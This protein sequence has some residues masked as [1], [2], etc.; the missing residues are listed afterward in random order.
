MRMSSVLPSIKCSTC[1]QDIPLSELGEH[2]C[3]VV[4]ERE[5]EPRCFHEKLTN[6]KL[7]LYHRWTLESTL[8]R[9]YMSRTIL[10]ERLCSLS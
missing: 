3:G 7:Q 1:A 8:D 2:V 5:L 10:R 4:S 6:V 9:N